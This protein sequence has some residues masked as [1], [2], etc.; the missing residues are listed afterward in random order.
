MPGRTRGQGVPKPCRWGQ[1]GRGPL[2]QATR[3]PG[4]K[5]QGLTTRWARVPATTVTLPPPSPTPRPPPPAMLAGEGASRLV[6]PTTKLRRGFES[7]CFF[8]RRSFPAAPPLDGGVCVRPQ[9]GA[10]HVLD[11]DW[12]E[13]GAEPSDFGTRSEPSDSAVLCRVGPKLRARHRPSGALLSLA[14]P[15]TDWEPAGRWASVRVPGVSEV[16][17]RSRLRPWLSGLPAR[18]G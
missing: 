12:Y 1:G 18:L 9:G 6:R 10:V 16:G 11:V 5:M 8:H 3:P 4:D 7:G 13:Q 15:L 2:V 17:A 14:A